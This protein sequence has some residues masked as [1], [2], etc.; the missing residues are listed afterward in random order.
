[1]SNSSLVSVRVWSPNKSSRNGAR[2][3]K[4]TVHHAAMVGSA[5]AIGNVFK[6]AS[7]Q[8]S[9][10]YGI[11]VGGEVGQYVDEAYRPWTSSSYA[12]D[13]RAV[14]IEVANSSAGGDWPV[15]AASWNS[16]VNL[17]VDVCRR[18]G[19]SRLN[20]T[21]TSSGNLTCHY[22]FAATACPGPYLKARMGQLASEVNA[23]LGSGAPVTGVTSDGKLV[24]DG[25]WG[26]ATSL[27]AQQVAGA[28]YKD[29]VVS[30]QNPQHKSRLKACTSGWEFVAPAGAVPGSPLVGLLQKAWGADPDNFMGPDTINKMIA[31]YMDESGATQLDGKLDYPSPTVM[32]FQR[33]LNEGRI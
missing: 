13:R 20:W 24:V 4:I 1:M 15:S 33:H 29:G 30:R 31:Y 28:P 19:I 11:G 21:G 32:V 9:A 10:T 25:I 27:R 23:K 5:Q 2:I 3:D 22:M 17:C 12:N 8:A 18:N 7:R 26:S 14:T 6:P 16:L